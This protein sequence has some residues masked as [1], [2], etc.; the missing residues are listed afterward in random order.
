MSRRLLDRLMLGVV[1]LSGVGAGVA[2]VTQDTG[3]KPR[4]VIR[5]APTTTSSRSVLPTTS[6]STRAKASATP[7]P[8]PNSSAKKATPKPKPKPTETEEQHEAYY[9]S[10]ADAREAGVTPLYEGDPGYS[11]KLDRDGD[12]VACE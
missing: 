4:S 1:A 5:P 9:S 10:C 12:G 11:R 2:V 7:K 6:A 8:K 3:E